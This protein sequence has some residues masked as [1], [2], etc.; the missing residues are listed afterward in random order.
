MEDVQEALAGVVGVIALAFTHVFG[1][2]QRQWPVG[3]AEAEEE[4][5]EARRPLFFSWA[6]RGQGCRGERAVQA[7]AKAHRLIGQAQRMAEARQVGVFCFE[8]AQG[9]EEIVLPG[10]GLHGLERVH[11]VGRRPGLAFHRMISP[12]SVVRSTVSVKLL[13][14]T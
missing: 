3:A 1:E 5:L 8:P 2:V 11:R 12:R 10:L 4:L 6:Y 13:M 14:D 9:L 7:L